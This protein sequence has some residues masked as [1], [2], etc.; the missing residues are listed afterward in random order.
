MDDT[1]AT[2]PSPHS[3]T[4]QR[5]GKRPTAGQYLEYAITRA[6]GLV[7]RHIPVDA[8]SAIGGAVLGTIMP[9]T[10]RNTRAMENMAF[11]MPEKS[12]A[13]IRALTKAMWHHLGRVF[14]EAFQID[15]LTD[16]ISRVELP[17]DFDHYKARVADGAI[18]AALHLGNWEIA[19]S[20][21]RKA[22]LEIAGVYQK[23]HNPM[24]EDYL[25]QMRESAYP[26]GLY[27]KGPE[28]G[29]TLIQLARKGAGV[30]IVAD[31]REKRGIGVNFFGHPAFATPL[32]AMLARMAGKPLIVGA[33]VRTKG[34]HFRAMLE[35]VPVNVTD[36]RDRDIAEATQAL[37]DV[38][39][40]WIRETPSQWMWTHRKWARSNRRELTVN[41]ASA[42]DGASVSIP[43]SAEIAP[44]AADERPPATAARQPAVHND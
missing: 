20:L 19:G 9:L 40:R 25:R 6:L 23:L 42:S 13:E 26:K 37:H 17:A 15:R 36:D 16:D 30:G 21:P 43:P 11:A 35:E 10:S 41:T 18:A 8:A 7:L 1:S 44:S 39:E 3:K 2:K 34:V 27:S 29:H 14:G 33:V 28:L 38:Y 12:E 5:A 24:V 32:P 31:F 22:G 4:R